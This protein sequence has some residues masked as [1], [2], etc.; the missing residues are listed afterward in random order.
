MQKLSEFL[1]E[2]NEKKIYYWLSRVR[3][4]IMVEIIVP[5]QRWEV[6]F[7]DDGTIEIEKFITTGQIFCCKELSGCKE[8]EEFFSEFSD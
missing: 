1:D 5:G 4:S 7:M 3:D 6:E 8:I 2:L